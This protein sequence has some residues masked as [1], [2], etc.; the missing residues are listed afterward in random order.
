MP[1]PAPP[2]DIAAARALVQRHVGAD[3]DITPCWKKPALV[4]GDGYTDDS[5]FYFAVVHSRMSHVG[6]TRHVAVD[7][8]TGVIVEL[9]TLGD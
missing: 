3:M 7:R 8:K 2:L 9:G 6:G 5:H 1:S 4:Y